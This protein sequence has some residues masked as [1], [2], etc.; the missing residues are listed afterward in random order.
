MPEL[1]PAAVL[2][3]AR[4]EIRVA[5]GAFEPVTRRRGASA[6]QLP[7]IYVVRPEGA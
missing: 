3:G 6:R 1:D 4:G 2:V 7:L 5:G